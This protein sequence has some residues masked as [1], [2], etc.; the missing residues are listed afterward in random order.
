MSYKHERKTR[1]HNYP[2]IHTSTYHIYTKIFNWQHGRGSKWHMHCHAI[3]T[4]KH[5][6]SFHHES[7]MKMQGIGKI[8]IKTHNI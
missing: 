2:T 6:F 8:E 7:P 5:L 4:H 3:V 1:C